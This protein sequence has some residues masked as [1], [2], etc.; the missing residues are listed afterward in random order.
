MNHPI[1]IAALYKFVP[2]EKLTT[3]QDQLLELCRSQALGGTLIIAGEGING[4]VAGTRAGIDALLAFLRSLPGCADLE[5]KESFA[6]D[7]P[8]YRM[9]VRIKPE[10]VTMGVPGTDPAKIVGAYV[11]PEDWNAL[12]SEPD[13]AVIDTRNDYEVGIGTF[14]GAINP[15]T[16]TFRQFPEW[17]QEQKQLHGKKKFA[18]F[19]TGGIRCEKAT[20][21]L[22]L[23]GFD[24]VYHLKGGILKYLERV[25]EEESMWRGECFVFDQR[26]AVTHGLDVGSYELCYACR[27]PIAAQ[28]KASG[29]YEPGVSCPKCHDSLSEQQKKRFT[30]RHKQVT[31][32]RQRGEKHVG[33]RQEKTPCGG[34]EKNGA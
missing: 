20:A 25:P 19:C 1:I 17:F 7:M 6:D 15:E 24:E 22:R 11:E 10:I 12:I 4:T 14:K 31:L 34:P 18:M 26:T 2:F 32:A 5:H 16:E 28:D 23:L 3:L 8:F 30:D 33:A 13:V 9:K 27:M 21:H 29:H